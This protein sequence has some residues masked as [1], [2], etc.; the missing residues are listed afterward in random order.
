MAKTEVRGQQIKD[1]TVDLAVDVTGVLPTANGGTGLSSPGT[2]GNVLTSNGSAWVSSPSGGAASPRTAR[3]VLDGA[4]SPI[5][6]GAK[7]VYLTV[8]V[9]CTITKARI[10][11]DVSGSISVDIW[12]DT[13]ANYP[14]TVADSIVASAPVVLSSQQTNEDSTLTGWTTSLTAGDV[15]EIKVNSASTVTKVFIDLFV[16]PV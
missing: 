7:Q 1:A 6:T 9:N 10:V 13:Y 14:P 3:F 5:T 11:A 15:L 16:T 2:S 4:G 12:K 8:P